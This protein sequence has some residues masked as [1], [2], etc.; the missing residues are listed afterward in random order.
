VSQCLEVGHTLA[1][2]PISVITHNSNTQQNLQ[3][4]LTTNNSAVFQQHYTM[5]TSELAVSY[6]ALILADEGLEITVCF[7]QA[8]TGGV[9]GLTQIAINS[10]ISSKPSSRLLRLRRLSPFGPLFLRRH[11]LPLIPH[12]GTFDD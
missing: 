4:H 10:P 1:P 5:S 3:R 8:E 9:G 11:A 7:P 6:A 12:D 2:H